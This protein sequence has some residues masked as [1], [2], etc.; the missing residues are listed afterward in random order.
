MASRE[1]DLYQKLSGPLSNLIFAFFALPFALRRERQADTYIG[2][3]VCL[4]TAAV[5]W[6]GAAS[7]RTMAVSGALSPHVAAWLPPIAFLCLGILLMV[8]VDRRS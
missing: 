3:V 2:I 4:L 8:R 1:A 5:Y 6:G 7:M